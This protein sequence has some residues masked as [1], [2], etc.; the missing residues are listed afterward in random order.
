MKSKM[1]MIRI[2]MIKLK[3]PTKTKILN[4]RVTMS[5]KKSTFKKTSKKA[6]TKA[7]ALKLRRTMIPQTPMK[8]N[9][10][11]KS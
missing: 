10:T 2:V 5:N 8:N 4:K 6:W 11:N 1:K 9:H 7:K 3:S